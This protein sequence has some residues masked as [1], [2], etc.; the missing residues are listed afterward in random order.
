[1]VGVWVVV[2]CEVLGAMVDCEVGVAG[3]PGGLMPGRLEIEVMRLDLSVTKG[4]GYIGASMPERE[5]SS[6][7]SSSSRLSDMTV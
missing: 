1:M 2:R 4:S 6:A 7:F 5:Y 3:L